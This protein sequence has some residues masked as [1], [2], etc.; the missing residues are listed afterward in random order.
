MYMNNR[1]IIVKIAE[2]LS[3]F[4]ETFGS[5]VEEASSATSDIET[6]N[7]DIETINGDLE[8]INGALETIN[9]SL[10]TING[11]FVV[12][13]ET[14]GAQ[15]NW[16]WNNK[17]R[18]VGKVV[19]YAGGG[20]S[21]ATALTVNQWTLIGTLPEGYR[22]VYE[23]YGIGYDNTADGAVVFRIATSGNISVYSKTAS[24]QVYLNFTFI[25]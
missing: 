8:T 10:E 25:I 14:I 9:G 22:P 6:I 3:E 18:K 24:K 1:D 21:S 2:K 5:V 17:V 12:S 23:S 16:S 11:N 19:S 4:A 15:N 7:G 13:E 20:A